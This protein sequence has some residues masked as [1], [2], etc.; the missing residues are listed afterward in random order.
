MIRS[1]EEFV[2]LR[3]SS[4]EAFYRR[5]ASDSAAE[6]VW[7]EVIEK[8]PDMR[9]WVVMNKTVPAHLLEEL[10]SDENVL[11]LRSRADTTYT[12]TNARAPGA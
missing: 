4:D 6:S 11:A 2:Q 1:A 12:A 9:M 8:W 7:R 3:L 10:A 5:A